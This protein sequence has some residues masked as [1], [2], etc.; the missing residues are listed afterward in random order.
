MSIS[1]RLIHCRACS[2]AHPSTTELIHP[3]SFEE[4][5]PLWTRT[6]QELEPN[7]I[8]QLLQEYKRLALLEYEMIT[9]KKV[10]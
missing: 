1:V 2:V 5:Y 6:A 9:S 10:S 7:D 4:R 8:I 3:E